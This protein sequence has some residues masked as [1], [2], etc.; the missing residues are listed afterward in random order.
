MATNLTYRKLSFDAG[1]R[2]SLSVLGELSDM[3]FVH[4]GKSGLLVLSL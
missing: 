4:D 3:T 2:C 1:D